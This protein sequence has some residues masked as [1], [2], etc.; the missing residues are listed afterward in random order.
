MKSANG[1]SLT[2]KIGLEI[3]CSELGTIIAEKRP[4]LMVCR[5]ASEKS[6]LR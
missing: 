6:L 1:P 3:L 5:I 2:V 4:D